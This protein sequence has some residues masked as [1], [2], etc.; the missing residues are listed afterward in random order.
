M[1][2][3][4]KQWIY[5]K[6]KVFH[7]YGQCEN[8]CDEMRKVFPELKKVR[9]FYHCLSWG[10]REH[11]WL[12]DTNGNIVDPT[13]SQFPTLNGHY[14]PWKEGTPEPTSRCLNCGELCYNN[15]DTCSQACRVELLLSI[16]GC[17]I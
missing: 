6:N 16:K 12:I 7:P 1:L 4:Y 8:W 9:G 14:E 5:E 15:A 17:V 13:I 11:W 10:K 3:K 2:R